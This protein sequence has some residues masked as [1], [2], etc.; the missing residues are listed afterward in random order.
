MGVDAL[1]ECWS[2][3]GCFWNDSSL[4]WFKRLIATDSS[5][6]YSVNTK[7]LKEPTT[8]QTADIKQG[9]K[10]R[11][12]LWFKSPKTAA[13]AAI[14]TKPFLSHVCGPMGPGSEVAAKL[15]YVYIFQSVLDRELKSSI[16]TYPNAVAL[17]AKILWENAWW[18]KQF[19]CQSSFSAV[20]NK[21]FS[22]LGFIK[23]F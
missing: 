2:M 10:C 16:R 6:I 22:H 5:E 19:Y 15:P 1:H 8:I 12:P 14:W 23:T 11:D 18:K 7:K 20:P 13:D 3:S 4:L 9:Y 17:S 21:F